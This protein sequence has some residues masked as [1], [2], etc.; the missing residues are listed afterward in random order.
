[1]RHVWDPGMEHRVPPV[2]PGATRALATAASHVSY[3]SPQF[4]SLIFTFSLRG[5]KENE[6]IE[7]RNGLGWG[8]SVLLGTEPNLWFKLRNKHR[9]SPVPCGCWEDAS[10][11]RRLPCLCS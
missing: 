11:R 1:M 6:G 5:A 7:C 9:D 10:E 3:L 8:E 2:Q 4:L